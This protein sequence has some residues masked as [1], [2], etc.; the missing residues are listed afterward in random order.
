VVEE[1]ELLRQPSRTG[2]SVGDKTVLAQHANVMDATQRLRLKAEDNGKLT[3]TPEQRS[4][5]HQQN[6]RRTVVIEQASDD[7]ALRPVYDPSVIGHMPNILPPP[8]GTI[9]LCAASLQY[10]RKGKGA[11]LGITEVGR[12][13]QNLLRAI[14]EG[15]RTPWHPPIAL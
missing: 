13:R 6:N 15:I 1:T 2:E 9:G 11:S 10:G 12:G 5:V 8:I 4:T 7:T 3:T 14:D